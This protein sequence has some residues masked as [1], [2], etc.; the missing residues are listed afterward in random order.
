ME[1]EWNILYCDT[2]VGDL[3]KLAACLKN[4]YRFYTASTSRECKAILEQHEIQLAIVG[5][6]FLNNEGLSFWEMLVNCYPKMVKII[7]GEG[8]EAGPL[9]DAVNVGDVY[10]YL[11]K[12]FDEKTFIKTVDSALN[13]SASKLANEYLV[14]SLTAIIDEMKFLHQISQKISEKKSLPRLLNEIMESSKMLMNAEASSL[15]L[16]EPKDRKLYFQVATGTKGKLMKKFSVDLGV[17]I[18]GWVAKYKKPLLVKDCYKDSRFNPEY[19]K[20]SKFRTKSMICV[21]LIRKKK[22]LGVIQ[23]INKKDVGQFEERDLALFETL[24]SQ[25]A[26]AIENHNLIEKQIENEALERELETAREIQEKLLPASLPE[27]TDIDVAAKLIPAKQ[28]GGDYYNILQ[29]NDTQSLFFVTDVTGKGIPAALIVS[30]I[31]ACINSYLK[32]KL[33][34]FDLMNLVTGM[35]HVLIESTTSTKF[36]TCWFGLYIHEPKLLISINA[37]HNPPYIFRKGNAHPIELKTGGLFLG[38]LDVPYQVEEIQ[39]KK[40]DVLVFFTDGVTEAWNKKEEEYEEH[41]LIDV[42]LKNVE[43]SAGTMLAEIEQDVK[44]HVGK[45]QQSDD[46]TCAVVKIL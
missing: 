12:P 7:T 45:A 3:N 36:A 44:N 8:F 14:R 5:L 1:V 10:Q 2:D 33:E 26:I 24:A 41:R 38:G 17:G 23:V 11:K 20:K 9:I 28:V 30:T 31:Y 18:A 40:N 29:I 25:C 42:I 22:L 4:K 16:Y 15:L 21:P 34:R 37:G 19:D 6:A 32:L 13:K 35:N 39:M 43:K 27:Y 46:F